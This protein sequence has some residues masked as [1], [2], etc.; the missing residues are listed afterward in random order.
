[1]RRWVPTSGPRPLS[2][3]VV[4]CLLG[5]LVASPAAAGQR[6]RPPENVQQGAWW[7]RAMKLEQAHRT[8]TGKGAKIALVDSAIDTSIPELRGADIRMRL[9]CQGRKARPASG[10][11]YSHGTSQAALMVGSGR[12]TGEGGAGVRGIAPDATIL[13]YDD[14]E[15]PETDRI[16]CPTEGMD[17]IFDDAIRQGA[18]I[19]SV[20]ATMNADVGPAVERALDA[21]VIVVAASGADDVGGSTYPADQVGVVSVVAVDKFAKPWKHGRWGGVPTI[22]APG[23]HVGSGGIF[24]YGWSSTGWST[25]TSPATSITSGAL[26]L[27]KAEYPDATANQLLQ[28]LVHNTG[29]GGPFSWD[30]EYGFG[31][32]SVTNMLESSPTQ[33]PDESPLGKV[34][35]DAVHKYPMSASSLVDDPEPAEDASAPAGPE[36]TTA[37]SADSEKDGRPSQGLPAWAWLVGAAVAAGAVVTL[38]TTRRGRR[39]APAADNQT[40]GA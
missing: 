19:I 35:P 11:G 18:D 13:A 16:E 1:M 7:F 20:A 15:R 26:A 3:A 37:A 28:H 10:V 25:G 38:L 22:A 6:S 21:G 12:G 33:W 39:S 31:I 29:G 32:V 4:A 36:Q 34:V 40:R 17:R 2:V 8:S 14:D 23:V 30:E 24:D 5:L 9:D 27:V